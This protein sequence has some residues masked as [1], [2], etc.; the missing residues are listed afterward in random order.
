MVWLTGIRLPDTSLNRM[1]TVTC[2]LKDKTFGK[3][4]SFSKIFV[5]REKAKEGVRRRPEEEGC[6][7]QAGLQH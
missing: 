6:R 1:P 7:H 3:K 4:K 5:G 2:F